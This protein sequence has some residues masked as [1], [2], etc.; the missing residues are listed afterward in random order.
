MPLASFSSH[1]HIFDLLI[2]LTADAFN[3]SILLYFIFDIF[4]SPHFLASWF[5]PDTNEW[6]AQCAE[7][8][9]KEC[10]TDATKIYL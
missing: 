9:V 4:N 2:Y 8:L 5:L 6:S 1:E 10:S 3:I 7:S